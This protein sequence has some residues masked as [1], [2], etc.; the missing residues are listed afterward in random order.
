MIFKKMGV[1]SFCLLALLAHSKKM[2]AFA[3]TESEG[4][5]V[6][7]DLVDQSQASVNT[8]IVP[9]TYVDGDAYT[10]GS[11]SL[12]Y[13]R[14]QNSDS[15]VYDGRGGE[16]SCFNLTI[17]VEAGKKLTIQNITLQ[18]FNSSVIQLGA[19][20]TVFFGDGVTLELSKNEELATA[21]SFV[22]TNV[23]AT[24]R[25]KNRC[26]K[27][28]GGSISVGAGA[29]LN[30]ENI[31]LFGL[32]N[33][34]N[35][36][37]GSFACVDQTGVLNLRNVELNLSNNYMINVGVLNI[38]DAVV[39]RGYG[40]R[41]GLSGAAVLTIQQMSNLSFEGNTFF[42]YNAD[43]QDQLIMVDQTSQ[44]SFTSSP[45]VVGP[46]GAHLSSGTLNLTGY[47]MFECVGTSVDT[48]L[49]LDEVGGLRVTLTDG[50][51]LDVFG[52]LSYNSLSDASAQAGQGDMSNQS[53]QTDVVSA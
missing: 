6:A 22:G 16:V 30:V 50:A 23:P 13:F 17:A 24:I 3:V 38:K 32:T 44:L 28:A 25:G 21:W 19:G 15:M 34:Q 40:Q 10:L 41:L 33:D 12:L 31:S 53:M 48:S 43:T 45:F 39:V 5:V 37:Q 2:V 11:K 9:T 42:D 47:T 14:G 1:V 36:G 49:M 20:S 27:L 18:N 4:E 8:A 52:V 7:L 51:I 46:L 26:L 29:T 35:T